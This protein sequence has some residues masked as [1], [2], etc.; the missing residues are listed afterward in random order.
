MTLQP[1]PQSDLDDE[2]IARVR[3]VRHR[4][5]ERFGHDPHRL[6]AHYMDIQV[7]NQERLVQSP[8]PEVS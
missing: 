4:I 3:I 6:V 8:E 2:E 7:E 5:S 1:E